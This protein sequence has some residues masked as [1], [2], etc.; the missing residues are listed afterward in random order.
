MQEIDVTII[1][2]GVIGLACAANL[3]AKYDKINIAILEKNNGFGQETSSR[4]SE[5]IHSGIY[6][7]EGSLKAKLCIEGS[8]L[9]YEI[10]DKYSV[11]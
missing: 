8:R 9:L 5:V 6:Y 2:A 7:P 1:G 11:P 10:C 3:S 4:N